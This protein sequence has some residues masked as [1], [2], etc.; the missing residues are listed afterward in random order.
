LS[1]TAL[2]LS[3][4]LEELTEGV[5]V[6]FEAEVALEPETL[7]VEELVL[8]LEAE[9]VGAATDFLAAGAAGLLT[10]RLG[11]EPPPEVPPT[12]LLTLSP[13]HP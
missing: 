9:A 11:R 8:P 2:D 5:E 4:A 7:D 6:D 1:S 10:E 13:L 12:A 3:G